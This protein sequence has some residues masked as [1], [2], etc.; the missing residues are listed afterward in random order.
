MNRT[1]ALPRLQTALRAG[2]LFLL[3]LLSVGFSSVAAH[4]QN[5]ST[6]GASTPL[7]VDDSP[8]ALAVPS[9][10]APPNNPAPR[11]FGRTIVLVLGGVSWGDWLALASQTS[12]ATPGF[13]Q[14]LEEGALGAAFLPGAGRAKR[15]DG[16]SGAMLRAALLLSSGNNQIT[17]RDVPDA[18]AFTLGL[19]ETLG[20]T[21]TSFETGEAAVAFARRTNRAPAAGNLVNLGWGALM[22]SVPAAQPG[23]EN[24]SSLGALAAAFHRAGGKTA[25][26]GAGDTTL[27]VQQSTPL[28]EWALVACD[29]TGVADV[30]DVS[31]R[32]LA[33]DKASPFGLR[34][35]RK[36]YLQTLDT[37]F[38]G[39][40]TGLVAIEWGDTRRA[41]EYAKFCAPEVA[42]SHRQAALRA[43]D[44]LVQALILTATS[45]V[46]GSDTTKSAPGPRLGAPRDRLVVIAVPDLHARRAQ[47][48]PVVYWRPGRN[49]QGALLEKMQDS[50]GVGAIG[51]E[52][53]HTRLVLPLGLETR[54]F[55]PSLKESG[56]P[57]SATRRVWKLVAFQSGLSWLEEARHGAHAIWCALFI[58]ACGLTLW[59]LRHR[60]SA[61]AAKWARGAWCATMIF[62]WLLWLAGLCVAVT[63]RFGGS[64]AN[65]K[66]SLALL[67]VACL[68]WF[69]IG[70]TFNWFGAAK[71]QRVRIGIIWF[72]LTVAGL[73]IGGFVLP[74][75]SLLHLAP[76]DVSTPGTRA[77]EV[78][79]LLLISA[80]LLA[81]SGLTKSQA[82]KI[83][84]SE[85]P[86]R[87]VLNLRPAF[88]WVIALIAILWMSGWDDDGAMAIV[89]LVAGLSMWLRMWLESAPREVR[90]RNRRIVFA[91]A[92]VGVLLLWQRGA[93]VGWSESFTIWREGWENAWRATWWVGSLLALLALVWAFS[94]TGAREVLRNYL[95]PRYSLRALLGAT[96]LASVAGLVLYGPAAPPL[97]ATFTLGA[98]IHEVLGA[99]SAQ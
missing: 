79:S 43:A 56:G 37:I 73:K 3:F 89:A 57:Q 92:A 59:A 95:A 88:I 98:I 21:T 8:A 84:D 27:N 50:E 25:A 38:A 69:L 67:L 42:E 51:L 55:A 72:V 7:S 40:Q 76:T 90:L 16:V 39:G 2:R 24:T 1:Y 18:A 14:V 64:G 58:T 81:I 70:A 91:V 49:G 93:L 54:T 9:A 47:W 62:P 20:A 46:A 23:E 36:A 30:G 87:R 12:T 28:R 85:I 86:T 13:R 66:L 99:P 61:R 45:P 10:T 6:P 60:A 22:Q 35:N 17:A 80:S 63:W 34:A 75:N 52:N 11:E 94:F 26:L 78:W 65:T 82:S 4:A 53:L 44:A 77:G 48:L 32:L 41:T 33:R 31:N 97:L 5:A 15:G 19:R 29:P 83:P 68:M 71:L 96:A 74:W